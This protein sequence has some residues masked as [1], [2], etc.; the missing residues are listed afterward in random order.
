MARGNEI[1]P[2]EELA[3]AVFVQVTS[4]C[5]GCTQVHSFDLLKYVVYSPAVEMQKLLMIKLRTTHATPSLN[6]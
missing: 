3:D 2:E 6:K 4:E 1:S 5:F